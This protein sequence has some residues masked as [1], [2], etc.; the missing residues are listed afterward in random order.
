MHR[1]PDATKWT[2]TPKRGQSSYS[3]RFTHVLCQLYHNR[4]FE[5]TATFGPLVSSLQPS[6]CCLS[7]SLYSSLHQSRNVEIFESFCPHLR[8]QCTKAP[9]KQEGKA[10]HPGFGFWAQNLRLAPVVILYLGLTTPSPASCRVQRSITGAQRKRS[11]LLLIQ[12]HKI[13]CY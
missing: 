11:I 5:P 6:I 1:F 8:W 12:M 10:I 9:P 4:T 13:K 7:V 3:P 2:E